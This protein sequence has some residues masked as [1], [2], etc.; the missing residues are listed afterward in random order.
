M[1][2]ALLLGRK[3]YQIWTRVTK[4]LLVRYLVNSEPKY[5]S[6]NLYCIIMKLFLLNC[7]FTSLKT[8]SKNL[9]LL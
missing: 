6:Y 1:S 9:N 8:L 5:S 7:N 4:S 3:S 2:V